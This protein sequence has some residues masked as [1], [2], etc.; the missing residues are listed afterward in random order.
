[1]H[2]TDSKGNT[3]VIDPNLYV[4]FTVDVCPVTEQFMLSCVFCIILPR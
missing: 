3:S 4:S 2:A 1:M